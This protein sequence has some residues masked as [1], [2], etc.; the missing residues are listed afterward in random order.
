MVIATLRAILSTVSPPSTGIALL[1]GV[2]VL[3]L[4]CGGKSE[5]GG[6]S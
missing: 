4:S 5:G 2:G 6:G 3:L 1:A